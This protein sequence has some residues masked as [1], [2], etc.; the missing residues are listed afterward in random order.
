MMIVMIVMMV[1]NDD[2][3]DVVRT[4]CGV[5]KAV[6]STAVVRPHSHPTHPH[7]TLWCSTRAIGPCW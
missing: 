2:V 3:F 5:A 1:V 6:G 7:P 4:A